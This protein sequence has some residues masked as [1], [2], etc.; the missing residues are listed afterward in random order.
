MADVTEAL[1]PLIERDPA[2]RFQYDQ[3]LGVVSYLRG[4]LARVEAPSVES[5][6]DAGLAFITDHKDLFG[7]VS[8]ESKVATAADDPEGGRTVVLDQLHGSHPVFGGSVRFH[9]SGKGVLDT[10]ENR[11]FPDLDRVATRP[12][13]SADHAVKAAQAATQVYVEPAEQPQ[14]MVYR[15]KRA[16]RL[17]WE[18]K[19]NDDDVRDE[20][21][22]PRHMVVY[23]DAMNGEPF[24][25]YNNIQ[26]AGPIVAS[27]TG[28]YSGAGAVNAWFNDVTNQLRDTTRTAAGGPEV[29]T[30][31]E[32]G[33]WPTTSRN[34]S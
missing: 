27:G 18:V 28:Y 32:D 26:T 8:L 29:I 14:L 16:P 23:V 22:L 7:S 15:F 25:Y 11:L 6:Y 34:G 1:R 2:L 3:D 33:S 13:V 31:D 30:N 12:D 24:L 5:L 19:L 10:V 9:V 4:D 20:Q 17:V 21:G